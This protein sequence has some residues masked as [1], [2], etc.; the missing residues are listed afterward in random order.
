MP[1]ALEVMEKLGARGNRRRSFKQFGCSE[2]SGDGYFWTQIGVL[3]RI[4]QLNPFCKWSL[5]RFFWLCHWRTKLPFGNCSS[6]DHF[7]RTVDSLQQKKLM[8]RQAVVS[9]N[10]LDKSDPW[11]GVITE[12]WREGG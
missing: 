7:E 12:Q 2:S 6:V 3:N 8:W 4:Q 10:S 11:L 9:L 5:K 1:V